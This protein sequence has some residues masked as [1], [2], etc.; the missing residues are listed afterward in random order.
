M[1]QVA[2]QAARRSLDGEASQIR[3]PKENSPE[4][5]AR[6]RRWFRFKRGAARRCEVDTFP[7]AASLRRSQ[8]PSVACTPGTASPPPPSPPT[9]RA[10]P[11]ALVAAKLDTSSFIKPAQ[12]QVL[13][14]P[15]HPIKRARFDKYADLIRGFNRILL[16]DVPPD[17]RGERGESRGGGCCL[18]RAGR[19]IQ[20]VASAVDVPPSSASIA[21]AG[22]ASLS[23]PGAAPA[24]PRRSHLYPVSTHLQPLRV[25]QGTAANALPSRSRV[26][27]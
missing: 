26:L 3:E 13:L 9:L 11:G 10:A 16:A 23:Q 14:V 27:R 22:V 17:A 25:R 8:P 20:G 2:Q 15:I 21:G 7:L 1:G 12:I 18:E 5:V 6:A 24:R 4:S 19:A